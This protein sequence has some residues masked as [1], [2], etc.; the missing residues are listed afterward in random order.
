MKSVKIVSLTII[1]FFMNASAQEKQQKFQ[2]DFNEI[3]GELNSKDLYKKD[4][5]RYDG[6][7]IE[8]FQ[9]EAVNFVVYSTNFQPSIA[10]VNSKGEIYKQSTK[11]DKGFANIASEIPAD[12]HYVL[13]VIG[14][15]T[16]KG[17]YT[18]Q[19]AIAEP[20]A[21]SLDKN[22]DFCTTLDFLLS[23][24]KA[25][26]SLL[27]NPSLSKLELVKLN[28]SKD[29]YIDEESGSYK[30]TFENNSDLSKAESELNNITDKIKSCLGNEWQIT[31]S[32]WRKLA[33]YKV[34]SNSLT[35][36]K[37]SKPRYININLYDYAGSKQ[38]FDTRFTVEVEIN[39]K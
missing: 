8:L 14:D 6:Y 11:N 29:V 1:I 33:D 30:A 24:A 15:E 22:A 27:E 25:Y 17:S 19:T 10:L 39:R 16:S 21:L 34:K 7:E 2:V 18:L 20:N 38:I 26:F 28:Q 36:K 4:F 37:N 13:Y 12:G 32:N 31:T 35:E 3:K 23:H 9:G 5:G